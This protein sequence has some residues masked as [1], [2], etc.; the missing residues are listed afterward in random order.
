MKTFSKLQ[1][2]GWVVC[3]L[4]VSCTSQTE[5]SGSKVPFGGFHLSVAGAPDDASRVEGV[6]SRDGYQD[7]PFTITLTEHSGEVTVKD[8]EAG[9]WQLSVNAFNAIGQKTYAGTAQV[10]VVANETRA[11]SLILDPLARPTTGRISVQ[12]TWGLKF[13]KTVSALAGAEHVSLKWETNISAESEVHYKKVSDASYSQISLTDLKKAH[14]HTISGLMAET[15]YLVVVQVKRGHLSKLSDTLSVRTSATPSSVHLLFGNPSGA[16]EDVQMRTNY[17][18]VKNGYALS[19]HEPNATP[20][21]VSWH[22]DASWSGSAPRQNDYRADTSLPSG[23][24]RAT[25]D[26][27]G[28]GYDR[29]HIVP[30]ADRKRDIPTNS[31]T[32][33]MTNFIPQGSN[34]NQGPWNN[35]EQYLRSLFP[36]ELY[37]IAGGHGSVGTTSNGGTVNIPKLTWKVV[38]VLPSGENDVSRV[39]ASTRTIAVI[40]PNENDKISRSAQWKDYRVSIDSVEALT[41]FNFFSNLSDDIENAIESVVDNQ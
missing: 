9:V 2:L 5:P 14:A 29:G 40:M 1:R 11:V 24:N 25:G 32:F 17:L 3:L 8:L 20:N 39:T 10:S 23:W 37:I 31:E 26:A 41:G 16:T 30:S 6:L 15:D 22:L 34:N 27:F 21:W 38:L 12:I 7:V 28:G 33:L 4:L 19:Y 35:M 36:N 18:M 13:T